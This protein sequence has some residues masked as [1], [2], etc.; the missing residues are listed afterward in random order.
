MSVR[1]RFRLSHAIDWQKLRRAVGYGSVG[2]TGIVIDLSILEGLTLVG[3]GHLA[4]VVFSYMAAV[5][6]N[7]VLQRELVY[8][9]GG[10]VIRQFV[11]YLFVDV[12]AFAV[13]V[14]TVVLTVDIFSVWDALP[15]IPWP[16][17][18]ALPASVVG[19]MLAFVIGFHGTD[20]I[21]FGRYINT[22]DV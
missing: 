12:S 8:G 7:F 18:A 14:A 16:V 20:T 1:D 17:T 6:W 19:I 15:Y 5:M 13:R 4:A 22:N 2:L 10:N 9:A 11:R 3:I 21:V